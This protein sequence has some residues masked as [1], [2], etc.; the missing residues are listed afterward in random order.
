MQCILEEIIGN[1]EVHVIGLECH[2]HDRLCYLEFP[3]PHKMSLKYHNI[4]IMFPFLKE[5]VK[6]TLWLLFMIMR[7]KNG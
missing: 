3:K 2:H 5:D 7:F 4:D 1:V 6:Y